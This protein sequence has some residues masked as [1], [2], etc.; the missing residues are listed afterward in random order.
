MK[1]GHNGS[2]HSADCNPKAAGEALPRWSDDE[3]Y[4]YSYEYPSDEDEKQL[5]KQDATE[6]GLMGPR[7]PTRL[8]G[9]AHN[10]FRWRCSFQRLDMEAQQSP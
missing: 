7:V 10:S 8:A 5:P 6:A 1:Q 2:V 9:V 3:G 4:S